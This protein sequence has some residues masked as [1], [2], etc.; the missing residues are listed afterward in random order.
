MER[1]REEKIRKRGGTQG[2]EK[3]ERQTVDEKEYEGKREEVRKR[4]RLVNT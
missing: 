2:R 3:K 4:K 1:R